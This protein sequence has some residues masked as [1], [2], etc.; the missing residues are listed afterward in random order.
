MCI[1]TSSDDLYTRTASGFLSGDDAM[2]CPYCSKD[3]ATD[4]FEEHLAEHKILH[5]QTERKAGDFA[6]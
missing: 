4:C 2:I 3:V 5:E 6:L 1:Y